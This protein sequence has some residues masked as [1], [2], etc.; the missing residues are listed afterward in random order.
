MNVTRDFNGY[1]YFICLAHELFHSEFDITR[2]SL[3]L[4]V[5]LLWQRAIGDP[6]FRRIFCLLHAEK[7]SYKVSDAAI[8]SLTDL[9]QGKTG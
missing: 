5:T 3:C 4:Q 2:L 9:I 7:L 6:D 8:R 1:M